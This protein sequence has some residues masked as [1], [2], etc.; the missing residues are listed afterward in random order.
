[1]V[2]AVGGMAVLARLLTPSDFGS[3]AFSLA[4]FAVA[5]AVS[6]FGLMQDLVRREDLTVDDLRSAAGLALTLA[7]GFGALATFVLAVS[8]RITD[9]ETVGVVGFL[10]AALVAEAVSMPYEARRRRDISFRFLAQIAVGQAAA[11]VAAGI[12]LALAGYGPTAL[13]AGVFASRATAAMLLVFGSPR[14]ERFRPR[15][16]G[17]RRFARFGSGF[18]VARLLPRLG[19]LAIVALITRGLG[20][21][22]LGLYNRAGAVHSIPDRTIFEAINPVILPALAKALRNKTSPGRVYLDKVDYLAAVCWPAFAVIAVLAEPAVDVLLGSQW[23]GAVAPVRILAVAGLFMPFTKMS[24][25]LFIAMNRI[26]IHLRVQAL[27]V[28]ATVV[29]A[30]LGSLS[31]LEAVCAGLV[32][33]QVVQTVGVWRGVIAASGEPLPFPWTVIT[34]NAALVGATVVGPLAIT[35]LTGVDGFVLLALGALLAALGWSAAILTM[36]HRIVDDV[37]G[38]L[39]RSQTAP[40]V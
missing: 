37:R 29:G 9:M 4:V 31:T 18:V 15:R 12:A 7:A 39:G 30:A 10:G 36:R 5:Q 14:A 19:E 11:E 6:E 32:V 23:V 20:V 28:A 16:H 26:D 38:V 34:R 22:P 13:A 40:T 27:T 17:W 21:R 1:M 3:F 35:I 2:V 25:K 8:G 33:A 24:M